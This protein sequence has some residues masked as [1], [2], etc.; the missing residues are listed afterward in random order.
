[1]K[2]WGVRLSILSNRF[3]HVSHVNA[4]PQHYRRF[5]CIPAHETIRLF[6]TSTPQFLS[7]LE[8]NHTTSMDTPRRSR[9]SSTK[10]SNSLPRPTFSRRSSSTSSL[11]V[12]DLIDTFKDASV[13]QAALSS[14]QERDFVPTVKA[15]LDQSLPLD[16][17]KQDI[18]SIL[19]SLRIPRW[20]KIPITPSS[21]AKLEL[22]RINGALTNCIFK[23][24]FKN[25]EPLLLRIYGPNVDSI[26]D[27][28]AELKTLT[29]LSA[30][31]IGPKLMGCFT[32]GRFEQY[33][34]NSTTLDRNHLRDPNISRRIGRRMKE[35]H[36]GIPLELQERLSGPVC[37][38]TIGKWLDTVE[39]Y[40]DEA[41]LDEQQDVFIL[42]F[43]EF[44]KVI[45]TYRDWLLESYTE[46]FQINQNLVFCH[47]DTQYG[48]LLFYT[49]L[50]LE[51]KGKVTDQELVVIDFEYSG[52]NLPAYDITNHF[53]EWMANYHHPTQSY[54]LDQDAYPSR[55]ERLNFLDSYVK[56]KGLS[57]MKVQH[58]VPELHDEI[59]KWR[60]CNSILWALWAVITNGSLHKN[61]KI[62]HELFGQETEE[63]GPNGEIYRITVEEDATFEAGSEGEEVGDDTDDN[64]DS[65]GYALQKMGIVIGDLIQFGLLD[66]DAIDESRLAN[67]KFMDCKLIKDEE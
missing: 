29:R 66:K 8:A 4:E 17:F 49:P 23:V 60:A 31:N 3:A 51:K 42:S 21:I 35:L 12:V 20:H 38:S 37:W 62:L 11:H 19:Q 18:I 44:K 43:K 50:G 14:G 26:I 67:V 45:R 48:N 30:N 5:R 41:T 55:E 32:N 13:Q 64:F 53:C 10:R 15:H 47:N 39:K 28:E 22:K 16:Y 34:E 24:T 40:A 36:T 25:Y 6:S 1:M 46:P 58:T 33:L 61:A 54:Y 2:Y 52:P 59:L 7:S 56:C 65:L 63:K 57:K 9:R 27:R